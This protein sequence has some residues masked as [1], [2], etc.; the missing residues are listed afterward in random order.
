MEQLGGLHC[1]KDA[2]TDFF[3]WFLQ[4]LLACLAFTCLIGK[5]TRVRTS[6]RSRFA[7]FQQSDFASLLASADR[8]WFGSTTR[9]NRAWVL[10]WSTWQTCGSPE[11]ILEIRALGTVLLPLYLF[12][13]NSVVSGF[14]V[15][16]QLFAG[17]DR[18]TDH[19]VRRHPNQPALVKAKGL[20][21]H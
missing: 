14:K 11:G 1:S 17:L 13:N 12:V 7:V 9:Q 4:V 16:N 8:G 18:R 15:H 3:G 21:G 19:P 20:G 5:F 10:S 6:S 2:L